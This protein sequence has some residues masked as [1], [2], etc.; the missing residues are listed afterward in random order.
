MNFSFKEKTILTSLG[1]TLLV[2]GWYFYQ[3]LLKL[4]LAANEPLNASNIFG[5]IILS[6]ILEAIIQSFFS[7]KNKGKT[8]DERDKL[9][10]L[11]SYRN[12]YWVLC[13]GVWFLLIHLL[14]EATGDW[15]NVYHKIIFTSPAIL[16][17]L[18]LFFFI[19][20]EVVGF[21]TQLYHYRKGI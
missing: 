21:I 1:I 8:E 16:A 11:A 18:L 9:I 5:V 15:Q 3:V 19:V 7:I 4:T 17:H 12:G 6:V 13:I 2:F 10:K 20:A 14:F